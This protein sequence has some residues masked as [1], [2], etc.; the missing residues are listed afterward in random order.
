MSQTQTTAAIVA[1][2]QRNQQN[3]RLYRTLAAMCRAISQKDK[4][5][6]F[7]WERA[8]RSI[9]RRAGRIENGRGDPK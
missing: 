2:I 4:R 1:C 5:K 3:G 9:E 8:A 7:W 6:P